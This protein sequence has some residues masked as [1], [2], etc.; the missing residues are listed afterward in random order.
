[1]RKEKNDL[2]SN[3]FK[4]GRHKEGRNIT[5]EIVKTYE[6]KKTLGWFSNW[7]QKNVPIVRKGRSY[8]KREWE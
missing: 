7:Q 2:I 3:Q 4:F 5:V 8:R 1:M 6:Q